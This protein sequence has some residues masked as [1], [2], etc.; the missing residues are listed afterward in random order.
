MIESYHMQI[1]QKVSIFLKTVKGAGFQCFVVGGS[2]RDVFMD[3]ESHDWD[4][5]TNATPEQIQEIFPES[6]YDNKYGTVGVKIQNADGVT[7]EVFE[8]TPFRMEGKYSDMRHPDSVVWAKSINEDLARRDFT[9]NAM[10]T[11][12]EDII[13]LFDGQTDLRNKVIKAVGKPADRFKE[14][15]LR[16]L[17]AIRFATQL[18]FSI[19]ENTFKAIKENAQLIVN[20]SGERI[21]DELVKILSS[22]YPAD[23]IT[24]LHSSGLLDFILPELTKGFGMRQ[25]GHHIHDVFTH[26]VEALRNCHNA[27]WTVRFATLIHDIG[28]PA[29]YLERNGKPTFYNHEVAGS[30]I[31][32][33]I[34]NR[35]HFSKEDRDKLFM[36][37]R[38]HMFTV[39]EFLTDAAIRRFIKRVGSENTADMLD[40]RIADRLGSGS[41]ETSWRLEDFKERII[42]V[43][44]HIPSVNDLVVD[45][46]DIMQVLGIAPGP[47]IGQ[48]LSKLFDEITEDPTKNER[49]Y[50]L[51][52]IIELSA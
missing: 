47:K 33:D 21:R 37:V 46:D 31:A 13:D 1:P 18:E 42:E 23:G 27:N 6:F 24:L 14:D 20:I 12:G 22:N 39:S 9:I 11:D 40:L 51:K 8:I 45:G 38:W 32:K 10:A 2:V 19:E 16:M 50:L 26:S 28:K 4:F 44:K 35:L 34:A 15:A 52:R 25:P 49:E 5:T 30:R 7:Q 43:Q 48:I 17:R 41:K 3:R 29:T 36:L